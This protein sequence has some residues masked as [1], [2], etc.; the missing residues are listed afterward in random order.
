MTV[1]AVW[2]L[3][4]HHFC[5]HSLFVH[6]PIMQQL[7]ERVLWQSLAILTGQDIL[8]SWHI[9]GDRYLLV[10]FNGWH[11]QLPTLCPL[12]QVLSYSSIPDLLVSDFISFSFR[13]PTHKPGY[14]SLPMDPH[15]FWPWAILCLWMTDAYLK[16]PPI[17]ET[18]PH[19]CFP[20]PSLS[21]T[22]I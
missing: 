5:H 1:H 14:S 2:F 19:H 15:M 11:K 16:A 13:R 6:V 18:C 4:Q 3:H 22:I 10:G 12:L 7:G 8:S 17:G 20:S 21:E 9:F